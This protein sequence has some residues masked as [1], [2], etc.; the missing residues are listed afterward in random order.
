M[1]FISLHLQPFFARSLKPLATYDLQFSGLKVGHHQLEWDVE[2]AFFDAFDTSGIEDS[3]LLLVLDLE[4]KERLMT[5][6]FHISGAVKVNCDRCNEPLWLDI[7]SQQELIARFSNETDFSDDKVLFL[8]SSEYKIDL[9]QFIYEFTVLDLPL[10]RVHKEE[11][12]NQEVVQR[13]TATEENKEKQI[14]PRWEALK[15]I[16]KE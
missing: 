12:C 9:T 15:K 16:N 8:D 4:R 14:D 1:A 2:E 6:D 3:K 5:L 10:K 11:E 7:D 13:L